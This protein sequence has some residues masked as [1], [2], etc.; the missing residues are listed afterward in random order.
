MA[1]PELAH[2]SA[3]LLNPEEECEEDI[4]TPHKRKRQAIN[5]NLDGPTSYEQAHGSPMD[6]PMNYEPA[7]KRPRA[8]KGPTVR[9]VIIGVWRDSNEEDDQDK[10]VIYG[11]IDIHDRLRTR[12]YG[13]NRRG[14]ELIGNIPTGAGGCWVTFPRII[15]DPHL[16]GLGN[17]EVKEYVKLRTD[18]VAEATFEEQQEAE[19]N[20]VSK[21]KQTVADEVTSPTVKPVT[22]RAGNARVSTHRQSGS[23][24]APHKSSSFQ[25]VNAAHLQTPKAS[26][27]GET[28]PHGV[29]L[30]FWM[31]SSEPSDEDKHAVY[32]VLGGTDCF[33]VKVQ[34][35]TRDGR[36]V[37]GNYP[38]GAGALWLPYSKVVFEPHLSDLTR[39]EMKEYVRIRQE[40][41]K[42]KDS[43]KDRKANEIRAVARAKAIALEYGLN[44]KV[45][46]MA[47]V[48]PALPMEME[49]RHSSRSEQK[50]YARRQ[51]EQDAEQSRKQKTIAKEKQHAKTRKEIAANEAIIHE[52]AQAELKKNIKQLNRVW[53]AQQQATFSEA[54]SSSDSSEEVKFHHG[55]KYERRQ[56]GPFDGKLVSPAQLLNIDGED[57]VEYRI[58]T[59]PSF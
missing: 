33:R 35:I 19:R 10:H 59:K 20:A 9:G 36:Y 12:I 21:A 54:P 4:I 1:T 42:H 55:I 28:K 5:Y 32:G 47:Q 17:A 39:P 16:Q 52:A 49:T 34:R 50:S 29:I 38:V 31:D 58:L 22:H 18:H 26:P 24:Q 40:E 44:D 41:L 57:Y 51:A 3:M 7:A 8:L 6:S 30:G 27:S 45:D 48:I 25:A 37:D 56:N 46:A 11:F 2:S 53:V 43:G 23:R 13:M 15:F 14:E